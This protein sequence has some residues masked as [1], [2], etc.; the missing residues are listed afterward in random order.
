MSYQVLA[1]KWRPRTFADMVGQ[2]HVLRALTNALDEDR[3]HHAFLFTGTRGV[4]KTTV[5]RILA[6]CLNCETGTTA[7]PCGE[8]GTCLEVDEGRFVDLIEV[9]AASRARVDETRELLDNV[10]Y[11]PVRGRYKVYLIDEVHM[12]SKHS[13]NALLKTLEE[14]PPHVKFL[15]ATT[16]P[17]RLPITV[18]SR[19]L[20]FNLRRLTTELIEGQLEKITAA[21]TINSD[22]PALRLLSRAADGS[23][24]DAL[25][26][27]DQAI[28][29]GGGK[30]E[31]DDVR[32]M[33][34]AIEHSHIVGILDALVG[35]D[36]GAMMSATDTL[37]QSVPDFEEVLAELSTALARIAVL[38]AVPNPPQDE[39]EDEVLRP[40]AGQLAPELIQLFYQI[41]L[42]SRRDIP[43]APS[44]RVGFE[45]AMLRMLAF[46]PDGTGGSL[47]GAPIGGGTQGQGPGTSSS[48]SASP[49]PE[50]P[51]QGALSS[52]DTSVASASAAPQS[53]PEPA[54]YA[55]PPSADSTPAP[56]PSLTPPVPAD[57]SASPARAA[58]EAARALSGASGAAASGPVSNANP[59]DVNAL[60]QSSG[61][62]SGVTNNAVPRNPPSDPP[63]RDRDGKATAALR[64]LR[65]ERARSEESPASA[66]PTS[67]SPAKA[68]LPDASSA[69]M[70][71]AVNSSAVAS[72]LGS[73]EP[74]APMLTPPLAVPPSVPPPPQARS[75]DD[76]AAP[77]SNVASSG[78]SGPMAQPDPFARYSEG[79]DDGDSFEYGFADDAPPLG[80]LPE[81]TADPG[82]D[83][84]PTSPVD[85]PDA[86]EAAAVRSDDARA[87]SEDDQRVSSPP[88]SATSPTGS[89]IGSGIGPGVEAGMAPAMAVA[90]LE[91]E[92]WLV[93][94]RD[95]PVG[96]VARELVQNTALTDA[97]TGRIRLALRTSH[98]A[99]MLDATV[100][101]VER[102]VSTH[103]GGSV[104]VEIV[105]EAAELNTPAKIQREEEAAALRAAT[106]SIE[107]DPNVQAILD[108]FGGRVEAGSIRP[109]SA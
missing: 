33:L 27:L 41:A 109:R 65:E 10:Q 23:M 7:T 3:L 24:R 35:R 14:P 38:Q 77:A 1:R 18:L 19:C 105:T 52:G 74:T 64:A 66:S 79:S 107:S 94:A 13:F 59:V 78:E 70:A 93:I 81:P 37:A 26:L 36:A 44:P 60:G 20:Q 106:A 51:S 56:P 97:S 21:E 84:I 42:T 100:E 101:Q 87:A 46:S 15:L 48:S 45:M 68:S 73:A 72:G 40:Y 16:D 82:T 71:S 102:A 88:R 34:G 29:Y 98:N 76:C 32:A 58:L 108:R 95:L 61:P 80:S 62:T 103:F 67:A 43:L 11:A 22:A 92:D 2:Q 91:P 54:S 4:G 30:L 86:G 104:R 83:P 31:E 12:F 55:A 47:P 9:D 53:A 85:S 75:K 17:Q 63:T 28:A 69:G 49:A 99:L 8:C 25:S 57:R 39:L 6:K 50:A 89:G 5:A 90:G 96:G